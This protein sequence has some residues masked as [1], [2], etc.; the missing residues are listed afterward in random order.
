MK[1]KPPTSSKEVRA[2]LDAI[3]SSTLLCWQTIA[4]LP[5]VPLPPGSYFRK[6]IETALIRSLQNN[7]QLIQ[8]VEML[9][10]SKDGDFW[11]GVRECARPIQ[12]KPHWHKAGITI[13]SAVF[14]TYEPEKKPLVKRLS[15]PIPLVKKMSKPIPLVKKI[16]QPIQLIRKAD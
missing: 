4:N 5:P 9:M 10:E 15:Q 16:S 6:G 8:L 13:N 14:E 2:R 1:K 3:K 12:G 7:E 11:D